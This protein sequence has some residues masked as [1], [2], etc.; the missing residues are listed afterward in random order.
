MNHYKKVI[1]EF[2]KSHDKSLLKEFKCES[3][4]K[5]GCGNSF[6]TNYWNRKN[7]IFE[8]YNH[9]TIEDKTLIKWLLKEEGKG[10]ELDIP[11]YTKD[12]CAYMLYKHIEL[13]DIYDL[14]NAKFGAGTDARFFIDI[15]LVFGIDKEQTKEFLSKQEKNKKLNNEILKTIRYYESNPNAR[16]RSREE[17][18]HFFETKKIYQ[19]KT[20]LEDIEQEIR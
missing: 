9:Y 2:G 11:V 12:L 5:T 20:E 15:E 18:I 17:Y 3:N 6:D 16:F 19:I 14:Y 1:D 8:L 10:F 4:E 13:K 7:L